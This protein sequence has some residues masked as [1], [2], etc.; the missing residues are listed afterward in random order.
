[1]LYT[2]F[3]TQNVIVLYTRFHIMKRNKKTIK[4]SLIE[5][6]I[7]FSK[8]KLNVRIYEIGGFGCG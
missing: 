7:I 4:Q 1:M 3:F 6:M 5:L 8:R 2:P